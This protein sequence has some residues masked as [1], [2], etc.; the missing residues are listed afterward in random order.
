[1]RLLPVGPDHG[2]RGAAEAQPKPTDADID[3]AMT[4][5]CR[6]GTYQ[7]I[8]AAIHLA[9]GDD[10]GPARSSTW[11]EPPMTRATPKNPSRRR[12]VVGTAPPAAGSRSASPAA[13]RGGPGRQA[14]RRARRGQRVGGHQ[15]RRHC[16]IRIARAEMGQGTHTGLAQ[17]VAEELE[18]DWKKVTIEPITPH[19][20]LARTACG[21]TCRPAAA[22]ASAA[23]T[24]TCGRAGARAH[25]CCCRPRPTRLDVPV[26][27]LTA[28]DGV[29]THAASGRKV[30]LRRRSPA[31]AAKLTPPDRRAIKLKD[32]RDWKVAGKPVKRWTRAPKV[33]GTHSSRIDLEMPGM[34]NAAIKDCPVFGGR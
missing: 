3:E 4:N 31:D 33:N 10:Q 5:I 16:V 14:H 22:A 26:G 11:K 6:C 34:L 30:D 18:C 9:A 12:F 24:I 25:R 7:R 20:N 28:A 23:P 1:V 32:P 29:I 13:G 2:G 27:E 15:A 8:R 21:R 17:L 19:A